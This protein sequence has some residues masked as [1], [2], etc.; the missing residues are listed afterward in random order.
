QLH[1]SWSSLIEREL[2]RLASLERN[3][4]TAELDEI[5]SQ[6]PK[7]IPG[8]LMRTLWRLLL[9]G[10]VKSTTNRLD[11]YRWKMRLKLEEPTTTLRLEL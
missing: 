11:L 2:D 7:A 4:K 5:R 9:S 10:R 1:D 8:A 3:G 6:A